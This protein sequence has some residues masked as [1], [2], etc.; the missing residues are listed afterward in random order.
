MWPGAPGSFGDPAQGWWS[1]PR[2][3]GLGGNKMHRSA[4][5]NPENTQRRCKGQAA[6]TFPL[7]LAL[8]RANSAA[9]TGCS[10]RGCKVCGTQQFWPPPLSLGAAELGY[11]IWVSKA[12]LSF[13]GVRDK[14]SNCPPAPG[15]PWVGSRDT[16][17]SVTQP[18][19]PAP[20]CLLQSTF[21]VLP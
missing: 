21:R 20:R 19:C 2:Q 1:R 14:R 13:P 12:G 7:S 11:S 17:P 5:L 15:S 3:E 18:G 8:N 9:T 16:A 6:Q 10:Q 4:A